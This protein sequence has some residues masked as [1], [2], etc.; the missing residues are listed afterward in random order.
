MRLG[1]AQAVE[2]V[3]VIDQDLTRR[4][5]LLAL[6]L[7]VQAGQ[8]D[9]RGRPPSGSSACGST[10]PSRCC[11]PRRCTSSGCT[12]SP[13]RCSPVPPPRRQQHR[14]PARPDE[15]VPASGQ[16]RRRCPDRPPGRC[17]AREA[18][19]ACAADFDYPAQRQAIQVLRARASSTRSL[20]GWRPSSSNRR[21]RSS[22]TSRSPP[23]TG[24]PDSATSS[25]ASR[26]QWSR[27]APMT[28]ASACKWR[29]S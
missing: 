20:R 7:A 12:S 15:P 9:R 14:R 26:K 19:R 18:H 13:R 25:E 28:A 2:S 16:H 3:E 5:E 29:P 22:S 1:R 10:A 11:L 8:V 24:P 4:R 17:A 6:R 21:S 27:S 23:I